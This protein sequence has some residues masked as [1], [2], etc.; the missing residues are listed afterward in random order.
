MEIVR[1]D[2]AQR[3][4]LLTSWA[5]MTSF[6]ASLCFLRLLR[7]AAKLS[8]AWMEDTVLIQSIHCTLWPMTDKMNFWFHCI[9]GEGVTT[10]KICWNVR[11][12]GGR[13]RIS[14]LIMVCSDQWFCQ[15]ALWP[16]TPQKFVNFRPPVMCD[17]WIDWISTVYQDCHTPQKEIRQIYDTLH[18]VMMDYTTTCGCSQCCAWQVRVLGF[19]KF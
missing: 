7:M 2:V 10:R 16:V 19:L 18:T 8:M 12:Q 3:T 13:H 4:L 1:W 5:W 11:M 17:W 14:P 6:S 15:W 9:A